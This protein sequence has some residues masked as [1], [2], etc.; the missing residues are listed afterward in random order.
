MIVAT[1]SAERLRRSCR[2]R[3]TAPASVASCRRLVD[4][5]V[6][7]KKASAVIDASRQAVLCDPSRC[8]SVCRLAARARRPAMGIISDRP[9]EIEDRAVPRHWEGDLSTGEPNKT[10]I[11]HSRRTLNPLHEAA[12]LSG[13]ARCRAGPRCARH[14]DEGSPCA[15]RWLARLEPERRAG[16]A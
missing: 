4:A 16:T 13:R 8:R 6:P 9:A 15:P 2:F 14:W 3:R 10:A 11:G 12:A 5:G 7:V 1:L